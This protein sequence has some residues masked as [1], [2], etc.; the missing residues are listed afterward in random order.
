MAGGS[1]AEARDGDGT[2]GDDMAAD[3]SNVG[4]MPEAELEEDAVV[5][6]TIGT[7]V[8]MLLKCWLVS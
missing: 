1:G 7:L 4:R 8:S 3:D 2:G 5:V 6:A